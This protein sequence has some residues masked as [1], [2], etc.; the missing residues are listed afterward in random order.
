MLYEIKWLDVASAYKT[1]EMTPHHSAV[2]TPTP[3]GDLNLFGWRPS[4]SLTSEF[5]WRRY[6]GLALAPLLYYQHRCLECSRLAA[7]PILPDPYGN[8]PHSNDIAENVQKVLC[9]YLIS[10]GAPDFNKQDWIAFYSITTENAVNY[11][12]TTWSV[13][14]PCTHLQLEI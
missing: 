10:I 1:R 5:S 8:V 4:P 3:T 11:L 9:H 13:P 14:A 7:E 2:G 6:T 12:T